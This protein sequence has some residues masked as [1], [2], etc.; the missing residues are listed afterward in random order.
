MAP[1]P[2]QLYH[3]STFLVF[4]LLPIVLF[5]AIGALAYPE[6][7][8][9]ESGG[10]KVYA[11]LW[12]SCTESSTG[13]SCEKNKDLDVYEKSKSKMILADNVHMCNGLACCLIK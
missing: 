2:E 12:E 4:I 7:T 8:V 3:A 6:W 11:G 5:L 1:P 10:L 13:K 9:Y